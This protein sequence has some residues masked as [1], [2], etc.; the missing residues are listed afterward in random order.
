MTIREKIITRIAQLSNE[1]ESLSSLA[2][3]QLDLLDQTGAEKEHYLA[4]WEDIKF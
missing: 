2:Q 4:F 1:N 3:N